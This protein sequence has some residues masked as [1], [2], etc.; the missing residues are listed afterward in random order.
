MRDLDGKNAAQATELRAFAE[1][2]E[3][4][5]RLLELDVTSLC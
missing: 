3:G 2:K 5:L 1:G 4:T